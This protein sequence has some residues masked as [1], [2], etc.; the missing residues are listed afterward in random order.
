MTNKTITLSREAVEVEAYL[1][2]SKEEPKH[3]GVRLFVDPSCYDANT[4]TLPLMTVAQHERIVAA[5]ADPLPPTHC[6]H[7][8]KVVTECDLCAVPLAG[9]EPV[10]RYNT[11]VSH[12][13]SYEHV[14]LEEFKNGYVVKSV[15]HDAIVTRLQAE[16]KRLATVLKDRSTHIVALDDENKVLQSELTKARELIV[17]LYTNASPALFSPGQRA[18]VEAFIANQSAPV[19]VAMPDLTELREYHVKA[20]GELKAYADD[21]G[22]RESEVKHYRKRAAVH[23][24]FVAVIDRVKS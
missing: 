12:G 2:R 14:V 3:R 23:E 10:K 21:S 11:A 24:V 4:E 16:V 17:S 7:G 18:A 15:D 6:E 9:V 19:A 20:A 8:V 1:V 13:G 22:M 5:L